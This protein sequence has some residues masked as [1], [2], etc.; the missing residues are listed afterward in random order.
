MKRRVQRGT[1]PKF[2]VPRTEVDEGGAQDGRRAAS[3]EADD[4]GLG[5]DLGEGVKKARVARFVQLARGNQPSVALHAHLDQVARDG[6]GLPDAASRHAG[7]HLGQQ[8]RLVLGQIAA[9]KAPDVLVADGAEAGVRDV[10]RDGGRDTGVEADDA[11]VLHN[12]HHHAPEVVFRPDKVGLPLQLQTGLGDVDGDC[13][14]QKQR[15]SET[16]DQHIEQ[17]EAVCTTNMP[18]SSWR[19]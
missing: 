12:V 13:A 11:L 6:D 17:V 2:A 1:S 15:V 9:E 8:G 10:A 3:V 19:S 14:Q 18:Q 16:D 4:A 7:R 5:L